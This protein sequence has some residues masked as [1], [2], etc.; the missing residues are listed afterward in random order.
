MEFFIQ[1]PFTGD[2]IIDNKLNIAKEVFENKKLTL[3]RRKS[4]KVFKKQTQNR[5][6]IPDHNSFEKKF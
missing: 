4:D 2:L 6:Y 1:K 5:I 3:F